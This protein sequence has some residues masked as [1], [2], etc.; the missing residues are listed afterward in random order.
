M[1]FYS[2]KFCAIMAFTLFFSFIFKSVFKNQKNNFI[3]SYSLIL[4]ISSYLFIGL[5]NHKYLISIVFITFVV[6][7]STLAISKSKN[8][9][10]KKIFLVISVI[11]CLGMLGIYKY[12]NFFVDSISKIFNLNNNFEIKLLVPIG[13][14]FYIF[15]AI[16][17][18]VDVYKSKIEFEKNIINVALYLAFFP[19]LISGPIVRGNDFLYELHSGN[20]VSIKNIEIGIQIFLFGFIKKIIFAGRLGLFV[21]DVY[22]TPY[23]F[24]SFTVILAVISYALQIYFDF[25]GYSDMAIGIA[26]CLGFNFKPNFNMPYISKNITEF[27]KRWH[28]S[29][30]SWLQDYLYIPLGGNRKGELRAYINLFI[31]MLLGG[32]W[33]G[34]NITFIIWGAIIGIALIIHKLFL[35]FKVRTNI[36]GNILTDSISV[37]F[38][39]IYI[40]ITWIF[41]RAESITNA[42]DILKKCFNFS[43]GINQPFTWT[44]IS[45][46]TV[47]IATSLGIYKS[48]KNGDKDRK[49]RKTVNGYYPIMNLEKFLPLTIFITVA[50]IAII[51]AYTG[52][53]PFIYGKF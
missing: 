32:L 34:A 15:T 3:K 16:S 22:K 27:W 24:S 12:L 20:C 35:K 31:T 19:K 7:L 38:T 37:L 36:K 6:Y 30:S 29:L 10:N 49:G 40:C 9:S 18:I 2:V 39:F 14:S 28:I 53:N 33:H 4:L 52:E 8:Q 17:Y 11:I 5:T 42:F 26:K 23:A 50:G 47:I 21:D 46:A 25:S 48:R 1:T 44:F 51:A 45:I 41:F 43:S 13:I